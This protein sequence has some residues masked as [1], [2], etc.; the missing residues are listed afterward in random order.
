MTTKSYKAEFFTTADYAFRNFEA[1]TP[2]QALQ[3]ARQF[4][5]EDI[6]ELDFRSYQDNAGLDQI[7]IWDS[8]HGTLATWESDEYR[9]RKAG[10]QLLKQAV[11][12]LAMLPHYGIYN[13]PGMPELRDAVFQEVGIE[14]DRF[15]AQGFEAAVSKLKTGGRDAS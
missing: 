3:L 10:P 11:R 14:H 1:G 15:D 7:Q 4:Y 12:V 5:E 6:G 2:E 13:E 9:L 8:Q